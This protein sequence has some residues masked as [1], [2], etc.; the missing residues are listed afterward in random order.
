MNDD[1]SSVSVSI[2]LYNFLSMMILSDTALPIQKY[3]FPVP[4]LPQYVPY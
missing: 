1:L 3:G 2:V 4:H